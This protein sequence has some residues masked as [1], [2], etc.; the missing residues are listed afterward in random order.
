MNLLLLPGLLVLVLATLGPL[1]AGIF[2]ATRPPRPEGPDDPV[3]G[4]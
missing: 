1:F 2:L 3:P 4:A